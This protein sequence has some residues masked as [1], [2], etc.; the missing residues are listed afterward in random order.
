MQ[1][2]DWSLRHRILGIT[3]PLPFDAPNAVVYG[4]DGRLHWFGGTEAFTGLAVGAMQTLVELGFVDPDGDTNGSPTVAVFLQFMKR[5][6]QFTAIGYAVHPD[7][8]D[9]RVTIEGVESSGIPLSPE[10]ITAF[11]ELAATAD[12]CD[13]APDYARCWWD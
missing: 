2:N 9:V 3:D 6:P 7:R 13:T 5:F 12:E 11:H 8:A 1:S 10:A 4:D